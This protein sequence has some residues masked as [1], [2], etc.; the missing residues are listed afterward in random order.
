MQKSNRNGVILMNVNKITSLNVKPT[1]KKMEKAKMAAEKIGIL[2]KEMF[3]EK[4]NC[5][6]SSAEL[7]ERIKNRIRISIDNMRGNR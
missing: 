2:P 1:N 4:K 6:P 3:I 5:T 7:F